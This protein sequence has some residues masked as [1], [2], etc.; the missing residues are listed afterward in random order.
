MHEEE[1]AGDMS[2]QEGRGGDTMEKKTV[3]R[4]KQQQ[5]KPKSW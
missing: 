5:E 4:L 2:I 1:E 3:G